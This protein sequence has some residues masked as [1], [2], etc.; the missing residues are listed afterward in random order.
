MD[1]ELINAREW[2]DLIQHPLFH[3]IVDKLKGRVDHFNVEINKL[4]DSPS[5]DNSFKLGVV[6]GKKKEVE[7]L[8][9]SFEIKIKEY[10]R[11]K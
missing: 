1:Q 11:R 4:I 3:H 9:F 2:V 8:L 10:N 5:L 7:D 6:C